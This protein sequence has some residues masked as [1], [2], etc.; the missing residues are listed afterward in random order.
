[1]SFLF[2]DPTAPKRHIP[3]KRPRP[4]PGFDEDGNPMPIPDPYGGKPTCPSGFIINNDFSIWDPINPPYRCKED[5]EPPEIDFEKA[6]QIQFKVNEAESNVIEAVEEFA[7]ETKK[8]SVEEV[9]ADSKKD[10]KEANEAAAKRQKKYGFS[11]G[12]TRKRSKRSKRSRKRVKS[13][14]KSKRYSRGRS[15]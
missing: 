6:A 13:S 15:K 4:K 3:R 11:G 12:S 10:V 1:M 14:A 5:K 7:E 9:K 8:V 2:D